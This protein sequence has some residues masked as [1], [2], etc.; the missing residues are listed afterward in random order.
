MA[1]KLKIDLKAVPKQA[2]YAIA[3]GLPVLLIVLFFFFDY[4][5]KTAEIKKLR[6]AIAKQEKEISKAETMLRKL[7]TLKAQYEQRKMELAELKRRLPE[8]KEVST[9]LKQV[10]DLGIK[11]GLSIK[12]WK[13]ANRRLHPSGIVYEIPVKVEMVGSYHRLGM[14]FSELTTLDRIVNVRDVSLGGAK[15][16]GK[17][18]ILRISFNAVTFSAVPESE[19]QKAK[20]KKK[21]RR[22]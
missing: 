2:Q 22:R 10:S 12:L 13:P 7:P 5:P 11:S 6:N 21:G 18:A 20:K 16:V 14:F 17:E 9:L 3:I 4:K 8:E 19:L 1:L 15:P